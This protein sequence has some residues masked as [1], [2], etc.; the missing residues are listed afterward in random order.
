MTQPETHMT[1]LPWRMDGGS[2]DSRD[3]SGTSRIEHGQDQK[4]WA[5]YT[6]WWPG[7]SCHHLSCVSTFSSA[8]ESGCPIRE[9]PLT[10]SW[11][12]DQ[13]PKPGSRLSQH[14]HVHADWKWI[15]TALQ[16]L[17][18]VAMKPPV[19]ENSPQGKTMGSISNHSAYM[20]PEAA[21]GWNNDW[22]VAA[23][24]LARRASWVTQPASPLCS[25]NIVHLF[26]LACAW[27]DIH[28]S[29]APVHEF[30]MMRDYKSFAFLSPV[31]STVPGTQV[32]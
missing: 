22:Q 4:P 31:P 27:I 7:T 13:T 3:R 12:K 25:Y 28:L 20:E 17:L 32:V 10:A 19:W 9:K 29:P 6:T 18:G 15:P 1:E 11:W 26:I 16:L 14:H 30:P 2:R 8:R 24:S 21:W 5:S 23:N